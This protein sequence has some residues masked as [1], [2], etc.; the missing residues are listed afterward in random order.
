MAS[1]WPILQFALLSG[2]VLA[3]TLALLNAVFE[4]P[5]R[6]LR[7]GRTPVQR[8]R[9][10]WW[11]L[12]TPALAGIAYAT[13]TIALP[14]VLGG[15]DQLAAVC[16]RHA[17]SLWHLCVWHPSENG[18]SLWLWGVLALVAGYGTWLASRAVLGLW[19]ARRTLAAMLHLSWKPG[20]PDK[21]HVLDADQ[22]VALAYGFRHGSILISSSLTQALNPTQLRVVL[23][24]E[25][26]HIAHRDVLYRLISVILSSIQLPSTRRRLLRDLE[27]AL[28]QRC[29]F[30]AADAVGCPITVAETIVAVEKIF[31]NHARERGSLSMAFYSD[32][33][34]ERVE[35]LLSPERKS[36]SH[37][38]VSLGFG[39]L[40]FCSLSTGWL[41]ALTESLIAL[42]TK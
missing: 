22:P 6:W 29:D 18:Q 41:H 25:Q 37:L 1:Q 33:L 16:S 30:A 42:L 36:V 11:M 2:F 19:R 23:A 5:L 40:A 4:R 20:Y 14:S 12:I 21:L 31:R 34:A 24:H 7:R 32:F 35:A 28:E 13:L 39:V 26:A 15:S 8:A 27:L 10:V 38:G 9:I 17:S 3:F